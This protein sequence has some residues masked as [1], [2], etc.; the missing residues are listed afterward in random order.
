MQ[1][2]EN[3]KEIPV[4]RSGVR[5]PRIR[6]NERVDRG[7]GSPENQ[8]TDCHAGPIPI[9]LLHKYGSNELG[10]DRLFPG[11]YADDAQTDQEIDDQDRQHRNDQ[12]ARNGTRRVYDLVAQITNSVIAQI[13]IH[14]VQGGG[15]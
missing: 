7:K 13:A 4:Q 2:A 5:N 10:L 8:H 15:S 14:N 11:N 6:Q 9:K 1:S 3:A 12:C